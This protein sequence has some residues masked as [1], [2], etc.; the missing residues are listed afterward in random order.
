MTTVQEIQAAIQ[1]LSSD[2]FT[3][4]REWMMELDW[5]EWDRETEKDS[6]LGKLDFLVNEALTEKARSELQEL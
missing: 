2:E 6:A 5:E 4:L 3:Y 1:S